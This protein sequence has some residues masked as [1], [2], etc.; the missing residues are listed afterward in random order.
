MCVKH[1]PENNVRAAAQRGLSLI[2]LI[3]FIMI[4]S[5]A[6]AGILLVMQRVTASSADPLLRKQALA[7]AE[8]LMEEVQ[9]MPFT[10]C[11]PDDANSTTASNSTIGAAGGCATLSEDTAIDPEAGESRYSSTS[12]FDNVSDYHNFS[13]NAGNGGL[14][15]INNNA[16]A[17]LSAYNASI[18]IRRAAFNG[19]AASD[20]LHI[21][22]SVTAP[23]G[24]QI[25]ID[26]Y[27]TRY[28]PR[29]T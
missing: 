5:V 7:I 12:P 17:N 28:S 29:S 11:D 19:M 2:E 3:L 16:I 8:S 18:V 25:Q 1:C 4:I 14:R 27:R 22:V 9:L 13:M 6:L 24:E 26:G 15:D 20:A 23:N 21:T 10:F